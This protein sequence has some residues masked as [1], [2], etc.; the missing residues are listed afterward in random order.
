MTKTEFIARVKARY[1]ASPDVTFQMTPRVLAEMLNLAGLLEGDRK[2]KPNAAGHKG[3]VSGSGESST[4]SGT[5]RPL[6]AD[7]EGYSEN[8]GNSAGDNPGTGPVSSGGV[9]DPLCNL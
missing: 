6:G 2:G 8:A 4:K 3:R 7:T 9:G 1:G 5:G